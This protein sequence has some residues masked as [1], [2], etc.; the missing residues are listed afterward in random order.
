MIRLHLSNVLENAMESM[1]TESNQG[2][3]MAHREGKDYKGGGEG[4]L[5]KGVGR[6]GS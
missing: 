3:G 2:W 4:S 6:S 5:W 1:M